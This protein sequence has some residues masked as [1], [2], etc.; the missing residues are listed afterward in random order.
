[1]PLTP[2][3]CRLNLTEDKMLRGT[4]LTDELR[5]SVEQRKINVWHFIKLLS[6]RMFIRR[7]CGERR[8]ERRQSKGAVSTK[9]ILANLKNEWVEGKYYNLEK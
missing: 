4:F 9:M 7:M 8:D 1:L 5:G 6:L 3:E 2:R